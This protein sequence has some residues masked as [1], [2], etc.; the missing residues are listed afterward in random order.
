MPGG[1]KEI[2]VDC[3]ENITLK[4]VLHKACI[5]CDVECVKLINGKIAM[6]ESTLND[7]DE[8]VIMGI[9]TGG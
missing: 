2:N 9:L 3:N 7:G 5:E 8:V 4:D 6:S 1:A